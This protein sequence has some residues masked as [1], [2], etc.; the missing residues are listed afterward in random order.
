MA[1]D[2]A[3]RTCYVLLCLHAAHIGGELLP[4]KG[5]DDR[6]QFPSEPVGHTLA[7]WLTVEDRRIKLAHIAY[8]PTPEAARTATLLMEGLQGQPPNVSESRPEQPRQYLESGVIAVRSPEWM[9]EGSIKKSMFRRPAWMQKSSTKKP[10]CGPAGGSAQTDADD[11]TY[12]PHRSLR[13]DLAFRTP[14]PPFQHTIRTMVEGR[15]DP[16]KNALLIVGHEPQIGWLSSYILGRTRLGRARHAVALP[17]SGIACLRI[18]RKR[19]RWPGRRWQGRLLWTLVPDDRDALESVSGKVKGKMDSARL[20][21]AVITLLLT[22]TL[23]VLLDNNK[24]KELANANITFGHHDI[25]TNHIY[26][27][28]S[29]KVGVSVAFSLLLAAL[30]LYQVTMYIYDSLLMPPRFWANDPPSRIKLFRWL[31]KKRSNWLQACPP[32]SAAVI[33]YENMLRTWDRLFTVA[34]LFVV[35]AL[36]VAAAPLLRL[37]GWWPIAVFGVSA[38]LLG[39]W[40]WWHRPVLGSHD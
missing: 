22:A 8:A 17:A 3:R 4:V 11:V 10:T 9:Q 20:L 7:E 18:V 28:Y 2:A 38:L 1:S 26:Y 24:W 23:G 37:H 25:G 16:E 6:W 34:N 31:S 5:T 32:S 15:Q 30:V 14:E 12:E 21:S 27:S 33:V 35:A 13:P 36:L 40:T 39:G 29:A 19:E